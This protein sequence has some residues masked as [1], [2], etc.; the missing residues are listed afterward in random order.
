[1]CGAVPS[2]SRVH[3][4]LPHRGRPPGGCLEDRYSVRSR[5]W[6][7]ALG[8]RYGIKPCTSPAGTLTECAAGNLN[9]SSQHGVDICLLSETFLKPDQAFRL[10]NCLPPH[11]QTDSGGRF[12]HTSRPWYST[13]LSAHSGRDPLGFHC[14]SSHI[15]RQTG[16]NPCDLLLTFPPIDRS[17][18]GRLFRRGIAGPNGRRPQR[19]TRG[20]ELAADHETDK[21]PT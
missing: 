20:L 19:Q 17:G 11:R 13:P 7:H 5:I 10:A 15:A 14:C 9:W 3:L 2:V 4:L 6:Q 1:M 16:E 21:T 18:P 8:G 12:S